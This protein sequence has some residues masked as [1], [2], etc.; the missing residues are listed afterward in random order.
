M[1][2]PGSCVQLLPLCS[3]PKVATREGMTGAN[4]YMNIVG[5]GLWFASGQSL[6]FPNSTRVQQKGMNEQGLVKA[7]T[8]TKGFA[9]STP[10]SCPA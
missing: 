10:A 4:A 6:S 3:T 8:F 7:N 2:A 9:C 1:S 5:V